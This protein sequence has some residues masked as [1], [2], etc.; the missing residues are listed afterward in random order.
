MSV[1]DKNSSSVIDGPIWGTEENKELVCSYTNNSFYVWY[2]ISMCQRV[3]SRNT[4]SPPPYL[5]S[6]VII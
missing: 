6:F 4:N 2:V 3:S 1:V 5:K